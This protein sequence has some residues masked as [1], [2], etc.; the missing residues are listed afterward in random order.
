MG[1]SRPYPRL[2]QRGR[3]GSLALRN[4]V[5]MGIYPT[6]YAHD[7]M[8]TDRMLAFYRARAQGGTALIVVEGPSIDYPHDYRGGAQLR[9]D[10]DI[11]LAGLRKVTNIIH[12]YGAR[13]FLHLNYP[14]KTGPPEARI[15]IFEQATSS[16][17]RKLASRFG[18]AAAVARDTGFDGVEVQA[19]WGELVS[20][21][22]SPLYNRRTDE[23]GGL[24]LGRARFLLEILDE[25]RAQAGADLPVQVKLSVEEYLPGGF[26]LEEA[27]AV[28]VMLERAGAA[29]ILVSAGTSDTRRWAVPPQALPPAP[30]A[31][32][33]A[34]IRQAV[35]IPVMA[36]GKIKNPDMAESILEAGQADFIALTRPFITDPD[37]CKNARAGRPEDIR[38][39]IYCLQDCSGEGV[40]GLGRACTVNPYTGR[41]NQIRVRRTRKPKRVVVVGGGPAGMQ[42]AITAAERGHTVHI[43]EQA[44]RLGGVFAY[45]RIA[46]YKGDVT[47]LPR[48]LEHRVRQLGIQVILGAKSS[49]SNILALRPDAVVVAAGSGHFVPPYPGI[50]GENVIY[51]RSLWAGQA[52]AGHRVAVIGAGSVAFEAGEWLAGRGSEV[53]ILTRHAEFLTDITE[54]PRKELLGRLAVKGVRILTRTAIQRIE[55]DRLVYLDESGTERSL[56]VDTVVVA[57]GARPN[58]ALAEELQGKVPAVYLAGDCKRPGT[59]GMAI[60]SGL[61]VG[62]Q[63]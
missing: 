17:L 43:L 27:E 62:M 52:S 12:A 26:G 30:L 28:A 4:R 47:E 35:G 34:R 16:R 9:I 24:L 33:A 36:I 51:A 44:P 15:S 63:I 37:W 22:L 18:Q 10:Q 61:D 14:A 54:I 19:G 7:S 3:I 5:I 25:I 1:S 29:S 38:G 46:G 59:G 55:P 53:A 49:A 23:Y 8:V 21:L 13:A 57:A 31:P 42:A 58:T 32:L 50:E 6:H 40:P 41:E 60:R 20:R 39:C 45:P 56:P 11:F 48:Y 2:F